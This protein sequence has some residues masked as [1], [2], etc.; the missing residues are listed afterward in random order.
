MFKDT[1]PY[2]RD[3]CVKLQYKGMHRSVIVSEAMASDYEVANYLKEQIDVFLL[4]AGTGGLVHVKTG[5]NRLFPA[6]TA[7]K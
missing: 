1:D 3:H 7:L 6:S 2:D 4:Q 5:R